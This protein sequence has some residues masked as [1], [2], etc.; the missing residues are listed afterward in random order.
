MDTPAWLLV[1][2]VGTVLAFIGGRLSAPSVIRLQELEEERSKSS[3]SFENYQKEVDEHFEKTGQLFD[4]LTGDYRT[5]YEHLARGANRLGVSERR[6]SLSRMPEMQRLA[7][8]YADV[9]ESREAIDAPSSDANGDTDASTQ[10][11][12]AAADST[13]TQ[14]AD[15][16][17]SDETSKAATQDAE[18][19]AETSEQ[20]ADAVT[21]TAETETAEKSADAEEKPAE[22][23][24]QG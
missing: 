23:V 17:S 14:A 11:E 13:K 20:A 24:R 3:E 4:Q 2:F 15:Q 8:A 12:S 10:P 5:L 1:L 22:T 19:V 16:G 21:T 9:E 6:E 7:A 18:A